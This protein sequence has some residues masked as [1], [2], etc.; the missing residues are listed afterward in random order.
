MKKTKQLQRST[1]GFNTQERINAMAYSFSR[2]PSCHRHKSIEKPFHRPLTQN[3]RQFYNDN[4]F[5]N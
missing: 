4:V 5:I 3:A 1:S 2:Y